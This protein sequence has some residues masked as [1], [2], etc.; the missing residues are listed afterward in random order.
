MTEKG[1]VLSF[2][3]SLMKA[4]IRVKNE[5]K[6]FHHGEVLPLEALTQRPLDSGS[7]VEILL[8]P[9]RPFKAR[10]TRLWISFSL[11]LLG[12]FFKVMYIGFL[13]GTFLLVASFFK[14]RPSSKSFIPLVLPLFEELNK[15]RRNK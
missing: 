12:A 15:R 7:E 1:I 11:L 14:R 4:C 5:R 8:N 6:N 10:P 3:P 2:D 9:L 13:V